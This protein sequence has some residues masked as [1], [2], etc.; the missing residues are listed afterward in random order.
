MSPSSCDPCPETGAKAI[1]FR[2]SRPFDVIRAARCT[3]F[4]AIPALNAWTRVFFNVFLTFQADHRARWACRM[5]RDQ[6]R[7]GRDNE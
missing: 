1:S 2:L 3:I 4:W 5:T 6:I 7:T